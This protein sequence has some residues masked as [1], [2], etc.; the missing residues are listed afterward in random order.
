MAKDRRRDGSKLSF[1]ERDKLRREGRSSRGGSGGSGGNR[2]D[3]RRKAAAQKS[4]RAKL[5]RAFEA[6][7]L[8]QLADKLRA[9]A[10][11]SD[12]LRQA[13][14]KAARLSRDDDAGQ[15]EPEPV[16]SREPAKPA[17]PTEAQLRIRAVREI[18]KSTDARV[19]GKAIERYVAQYGQLPA[20]FEVLEKALSHPKENIVLGALSKLEDMLKTDKP[21]RSRGLAG[22]LALLSDTHADEEVCDLAARLRGLL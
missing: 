5:E 15:S 8:E 20:D 6:G 12:E 17:A 19:T 14:V 3:S 4:Y 13:H 9:P 10:P 7:E 18:K 2:G 11:S 1:A 16:R 22:Q 21:R